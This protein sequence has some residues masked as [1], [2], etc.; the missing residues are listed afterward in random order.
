MADQTINLTGGKGTNALDDGQSVSGKKLVPWTFDQAFAHYVRYADMVVMNMRP[1]SVGLTDQFRTFLK[2]LNPRAVPPCDRTLQRIVR[3]M[4]AGI[5]LNVKDEVMQAVKHMR[6]YGM[7]S[8]S[9][10]LDIWTANY[11]NTSFACLTAS[12]I[13]NTNHNSSYEFKRLTLAFSS[14]GT[15]SHTSA[16]IKKWL[17]GVLATFG[18]KASDIVI[19]SPDAAA[20]GI[21]ALK[22]AGLETWTCLPHKLANAVKNALGVPTRRKLLAEAREGDALA[23]GDEDY[24]DGGLTDYPPMVQAKNVLG[25]DAE[26]SSDGLKEVTRNPL[27]LAM[28]KKFKA[29][30]SMA[31]KSPKVTKNILDAQKASAPRLSNVV[32]GTCLYIIYYN[33][34]IYVYSVNYAHLI[35]PRPSGMEKWQ[36]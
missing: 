11:I 3:C 30:K 6:A 16:N 35:S 10:A 24:G 21:K 4:A 7:G 27:V 5:Q 28:L 1:L 36:H 34:Y 9:F 19:V 29:V 32:C 13:T 15:T 25:F 8:V 23:D 18:L 12:F 22:M 17:D 31:K 33:I 14:F 2:G 20:N 26:P